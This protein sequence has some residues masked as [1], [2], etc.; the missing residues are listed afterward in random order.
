M[1]DRE[2]ANVARQ[3]HPLGG[4]EHVPSRH[5][6]PDRAVFHEGVVGNLTRHMEVHRIVAELSALSHPVKPNSLDLDG[7][8][9]LAD[10]HVATEIITDR[11]GG[12]GRHRRG[13]K[14]A[15]HRVTARFDSNAAAQ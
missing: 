4:V 7:L 10:Y 14:I 2:V 13:R 3:Q 8:E 5:R 6:V 12:Y 1:P 9:S 15:Q 11:A